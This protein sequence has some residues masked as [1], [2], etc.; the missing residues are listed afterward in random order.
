MGFDGSGNYTRTNGT[1]S[2]STLWTQRAAQANPIISATE[3]DAEMNDVA[4]ALT[5][6]VKANGS[7]AATGNQ[8][9]A[10]FKHTGVGNATASDQYATLGQ[11]NTSLSTGSLNVTNAAAGIAVGSAATTTQDCSINI[12]EGRTGSGNAYVDLIGDTT[13]S[14]YG[15]RFIRG[16]G[17]NANS[18][19]VHRGTGT[20]SLYGSDAS[21]ITLFTSAIERARVTSGGNLLVGT[22]TDDGLPAITQEYFYKPSGSHRLKVASDSI[23]DT[24]FADVVA[25]GKVGSNTRWAQILAYKHSGITDACGAVRLQAED[26]QF[27]S[28]WHDNTDVFRTSTSESNIGTTGG[29]IVGTQTSDIRL[30]EDVSPLHYGLNEITQLEPCSFKYKADPATPQLGFIAQEVISIIPEAVYDTKEVIQ[31]EDP[32]LTKLAMDYSRLIP[33]LVQAVK[34]LSLTVESLEARIAALEGA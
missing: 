4:T 16:G 6:C 24:E 28:L 31:G 8:P 26:G 21:A 10:G 7:K 9:M 17:A 12:G 11:I 15:C 23:A 20:L 18:E 13:Y 22:N 14:D 2:G 34:E 1:L 29:T 27:N 19:L 3:H 32:T 33:V 30:K 25:Q 5:D